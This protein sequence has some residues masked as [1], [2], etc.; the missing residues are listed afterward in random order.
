MDYVDHVDHVNTSPPL[1]Y[2]STLAKV[3]KFAKSKSDE[4]ISTAQLSSNTH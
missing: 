4:C 3:L 1:R 2:C